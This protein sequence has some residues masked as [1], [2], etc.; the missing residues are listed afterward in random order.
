MKVSGFL[1]LAMTAQ[2]AAFQPLPTG[3]RPSTTTE[4]SMSKKHNK[5]YKKSNSNNDYLDSLKAPP[6][7][8]AVIETTTTAT[9]TSPAIQAEDETLTKVAES[10]K[11]LG[12]LFQG[13]ASIGGEV[14]TSVA[15][16]VKTGWDKQR[17]NKLQKAR[18]DDVITEL[19]DLSV[20]W[21]KCTLDQRE[22][23]L[24]EAFTTT[25]KLL[26]T[27]QNQEDGN[28]EVMSED[29][30]DLEALATKRIVFK[31]SLPQDVLKP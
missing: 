31:K 13:V 30:K 24:E 17:L 26:Q 19:T 29:V 1:F 10:A 7:P 18:L 8:S 12:K 21:D 28:P 9:T 20:Q 22:G 11:G 14:A 23:V 3:V 15:G 2:A 16:Q 5:A 6:A 4:L 25:F 27:V